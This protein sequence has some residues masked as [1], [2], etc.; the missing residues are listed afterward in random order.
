[1]RIIVTGATC[2]L[3]RAVVEAALRRGH[4]VLAIGGKKTL[5]LSEPVRFLQMD[6]R[7]EVKL[8]SLVLEEFPQAVINCAG[9][10]KINDCESNKELATELNEHLPKRLAQLCF[11]VGAKLIHFSTDV[12]FD[13]KSGKYGHTDQPKPLNTYAMTKAAGEVAVLNYGREHSAVVRT[14]ILNGNSF[15]GEFSLHERL[16]HEWVSGKVSSLFTDEIRQPVSCSNLADLAVELCERTTLNGVY[17]WA[18]LEALSRYSIGQKIAEHFGLNPEKFI[19]PV[20]RPNLAD[21]PQRPRNLSLLLHPLAGK[22]RT[23][24]QSLSDQLGELRVP[25]GC[26]DWYEKET[27]RKVVRLLQKSLDY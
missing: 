7:N 21:D 26:E 1:M 3:G 19:K 15:T 22:L 9:L 12:V 13:G 24:G 4:D 14:S 23:P 2:F 8:Q 10:T 16:F 18:G 25:R 5:V 27:G 11:H 20:T 6:L 17:H